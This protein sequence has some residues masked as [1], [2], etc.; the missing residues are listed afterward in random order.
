MQSNNYCTFY[1]VRH[2][3][4]KANE[5]GIRA[6]QI[7]YE[8]SEKGEQQAVARAADL[9][10]INFDEAFS[11][12]L[13]RAK[14]TAKIIATEHKLAIQATNLLRERAWGKELEG[15]TREETRKPLE[16]FHKMNYEERLKV[17]VFPDM[18]SDEE[19]IARFITFLRETAILHPTKTILVVSHANLIR[20]FL[21]H[22]GFGSHQ[23]LSGA[24]EPS[25]YVKLKTDGVDF[26]IEQTKGFKI[27]PTSSK[28][29]G[30]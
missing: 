30:S 20:T 5:S 6:G 26:F 11:S 16:E 28:Y 27:S 17:K 13:I 22:I 15:K 8:L 7:D 1:I 4:S 23:E 14:R 3:E 18:E 24:L 12:D 19:I 21:T 2:A 25:G 9:K 10:N 29:S